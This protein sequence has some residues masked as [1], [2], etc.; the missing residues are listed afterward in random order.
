MPH[1]TE[2]AEIEISPEMIEAGG[3]VVLR[4]DHATQFSTDQAEDFAEE[5]IRAALAARLTPKSQAK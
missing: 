1:D 4:H 2:I 3:R 5:I